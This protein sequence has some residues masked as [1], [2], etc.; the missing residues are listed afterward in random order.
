MHNNFREKGREI[1]QK[2]IYSQQSTIVWT[3]LILYVD[4][5]NQFF[6][7]TS[8]MM[9]ILSSPIQFNQVFSTDFSS[10][11]EPEFYVMRY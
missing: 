8:M 3:S 5:S 1:G 9:L 10:L 4:T 11:F 6:A 2:E 7:Q